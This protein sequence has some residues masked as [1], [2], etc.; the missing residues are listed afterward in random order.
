MFGE[1]VAGFEGV[2]GLA[3]LALPLLHEGRFAA[4][5]AIERDRLVTGIAAVEGERGD[6]ELLDGP[7]A[8]ATVGEG[9]L[10]AGVAGRFRQGVVDRAVICQPG[11]R[12][13]GAHLMRGEGEV[14]AGG[15]RVGL[16]PRRLAV[17][18]DHDFTN[19][20]QGGRAQ[21]GHVLGGLRAPRSGG[22]QGGGECPK[23][24]GASPIR[25]TGALH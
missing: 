12:E 20:G 14:T 3:V 2:L 24:H 16:F 10:A 17:A 18:F 23:H 11:L 8:R 15:G 25:L 19:G 13:I 21:R 7:L 5:R 1:R 9:D 4:G 6:G 22:R